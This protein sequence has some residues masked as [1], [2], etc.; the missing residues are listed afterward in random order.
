MYPP[1]LENALVRQ[2]TLNDL[3]NLFIYFPYNLTNYATFC[4]VEWSWVQTP[5]SVGW[6][7]WVQVLGSAWLDSI[8]HGIFK[9]ERRYVWALFQKSGNNID[10]KFEKSQVRES[11]SDHYSKFS[12]LTMSCYG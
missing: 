4:V 8:Q 3:L 11:T 2:I 10:L 9:S 12:K 1:P 5:G 6:R 7:S